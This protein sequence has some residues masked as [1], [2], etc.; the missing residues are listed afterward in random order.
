MFPLVC[1]ILFHLCILGTYFWDRSEIMLSCWSPKQKHASWITQCAF[2][3]EMEERALTML[4]KRF[5]MVVGAWYAWLH[6]QLGVHTVSG[7]DTFQKST[8]EDL[9]P[10]PDTFLLDREQCHFS[11]E[12]LMKVFEL[13]F[14]WLMIFLLLL[15][16]FTGTTSHPVAGKLPVEFFLKFVFYD[17]AKFLPKRKKKEKGTC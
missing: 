17:L 6:P 8:S 3:L 2:H 14:V 12:S 15:Y 1:E 9:L 11:K 5:C 7:K 4:L 16:S 13:R 10:P